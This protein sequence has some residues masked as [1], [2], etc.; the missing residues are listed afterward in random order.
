[1]PGHVEINRAQLQATLGTAGGQWG[2]RT[3]RQIVN[4]AKRN[5]P[6]D[7]GRLRSSINYVVTITPRRVVVN[8]GSPLEYAIYIHNGTG[9]YGPKHTPIRPVTA[10][11]LKFET[12]KGMGP[13]RPGQRRAA[14]GRRGY[15]FA[16]SVR[17]VPPSPFLSDALE[18]VMGR[19]NIT[20]PHR[21][22]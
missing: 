2:N 16:R 21:P 13:M 6:V 7:E 10:K 17:G 9:I 19:Q 15:V 4:A 22:A 8:V 3:G 20:R 18:E 1:M 12:P 14:K 5:C 11:A